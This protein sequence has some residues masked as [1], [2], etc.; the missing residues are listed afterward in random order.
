MPGIN[1]WTPD[2]QMFTSVRVI[3][4]SNMTLTN[5]TLNKNFN[6]LCESLLKSLYFKLRSMVPCC[7]CHVNF[8]VAVP[9]DESIQ[10]AV[11]A[12]AITFDK[13]EALQSSRHKAGAAQP[14][15][16][17]DTDEL[18]QFPLELSSE[19]PGLQPLPPGKDLQ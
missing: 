13:Q 1:N 4:L 10:V 6:D 19:S 2:I 16:S 5:Q 7:L 14:R 12:V 11:T 8:T 18:L 9:E 3:R 17:A 15:V